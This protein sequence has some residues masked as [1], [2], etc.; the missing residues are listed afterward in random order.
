[1]HGI[2]PEVGD[3][4]EARDGFCVTTVV[5]RIDAAPRL[6]QTAQNAV[7]HRNSR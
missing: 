5:G 6:S 1:M 2:P 7:K 3:E 4:R